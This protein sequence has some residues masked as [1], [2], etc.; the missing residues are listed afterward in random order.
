MTSSI[1]VCWSTL[2][3]SSNSMAMHVCIFPW[4][5][6]LYNCIRHWCLMNR[7]NGK[8]LLDQNPGCT[9][10]HQV[11]LNNQKIQIFNNYSPKLV[12]ASILTDTRTV[13]KWKEIPQRT[14]KQNRVASFSTKDCSSVTGTQRKPFCFCPE[15]NSARISR[16]EQP[17][18]LR[19][20]N[21]L[22]PEYMPSSNIRTYM[23]HA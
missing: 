2:V 4:A 11:I 18:K 14:V 17:I 1:A 13:K 23:Q 21:Y 10:L 16:A 15:V 22:P 7:V 19:E 5:L 12:Q 20:K 9:K 8:A 3:Y 6:F